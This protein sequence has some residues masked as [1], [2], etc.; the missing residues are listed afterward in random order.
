MVLVVVE[1]VLVYGALSHGLLSPE[2]LRVVASMAPNVMNSR[3]KQRRVRLWFGVPRLQSTQ[4]I[5]GLALSSV[6]YCSLL[7][8]EGRVMRGTFLR[9]SS[10]LQL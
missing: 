6:T 2:R 7:K 8:G 1:M 9:N 10:R 5:Q 3:R 4:D